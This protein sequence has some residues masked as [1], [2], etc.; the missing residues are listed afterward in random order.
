MITI[1]YNLVIFDKHIHF[2]TC[3]FFNSANLS[4]KKSTLYAGDDN[5]DGSGN[6]IE[7]GGSK[8]IGCGERYWK[9]YRISEFETHMGFTLVEPVCCQEQFVVQR[10]GFLSGGST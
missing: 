3:N 8:N 7:A 1:V 4:G 5:K 2:L 6:L 9:G 10:M